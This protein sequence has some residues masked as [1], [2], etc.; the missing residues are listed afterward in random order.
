[1]MNPFEWPVEKYIDVFQSN[2]T[3]HRITVR[4]RPASTGR[5]IGSGRPETYTVESHSRF[6]H[7]PNQIILY[8]EDELVF[9]TNETDEVLRKIPLVDPVPEQVPVRPTE[10]GDDKPL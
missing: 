3:P 5:V 4:R 6:Y 8:T 7:L 1:M 10:H 2:G 9:T